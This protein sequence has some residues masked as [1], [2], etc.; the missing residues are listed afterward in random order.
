MLKVVEKRDGREA[1]EDVLLLDEIAREGARRMLLEALKAEVDDYVE[2]HRSQ[3][4]VRAVTGG[5]G[6]SRWPENARFFGPSVTAGHD[7]FRWRRY[8]MD[9]L[10]AA[11]PPDPHR[12]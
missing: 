2:R 6:R 5:H 8:Q 4:I 1:G 3:E 9:T 11:V 12:I 10:A 7:G